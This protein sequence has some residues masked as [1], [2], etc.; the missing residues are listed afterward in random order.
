MKLILESKLPDSNIKLNHK[1]KLL[2][3]GSCFADNIGEK[4]KEDGFDVAVNP[5]G[6]LFDPAAIRTAIAVEF[7]NN[8]LSGVTLATSGGAINLN[9]HSSIQ[10]E[11]PEELVKLIMAKKMTFYNQLSKAK[12]I[13][14]TLGTAWAYRYLKTGELVA[15]CHKLPASDY[16]KCLLDVEE[17]YIKWRAVLS[18]WNRLNPSLKVVFTVSPVRHSKK[19]L[20]ENNISKGVLHLLIHKLESKF[21]FVDYFPAFEIVIDELRD[22]R[23]Y[24]KDMVHPNEIA[25]DYVYEKFGETYFSQKTEETCKIKR[26]LNKAKAHLFMNAT[27]EQKQLHQNVIEKLEEQFH[28]RIK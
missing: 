23:F 11:T 2:S 5:L 15:N 3:I 10:A 18:G 7:T 20:R 17:E 19:G 28:D 12:V 26:S 8:N 16:E 21:D 22:Y 14:V 6:I 1:D 24:K 4:L 9:F 27:N 13:F 25:I